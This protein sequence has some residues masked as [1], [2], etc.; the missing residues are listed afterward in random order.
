MSAAAA[1]RARYTVCLTGSL[2]GNA[3]R[4]RPNR[5]FRRQATEQI[6][7]PG[8]RAP[9]PLQ[10]AGRGSAVNQRTAAILQRPECLIGWNRRQDLEIV[11]RVF[12]FRWRLHLFEIHV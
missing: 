6:I 11:E 12:R 4:V 9:G 7:G 5:S 10:S 1:V 3:A 8:A 2:A